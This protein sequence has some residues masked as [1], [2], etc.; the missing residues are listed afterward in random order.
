M[1]SYSEFNRV[2]EWVQ[3]NRTLTGRERSVNKPK[4]NP[5]TKIVTTAI[6]MTRRTKKWT[7]KNELSKLSKN[8]LSMLAKNELS[9]LK[10]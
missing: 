10:K 9:K 4:P 2:E 3:P 8:E 1:I 5:K 6:M 7:T